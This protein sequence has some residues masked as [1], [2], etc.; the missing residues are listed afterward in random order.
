MKKTITLTLALLGVQLSSYSQAYDGYHDFKIFLGYSNVGGKYGVDFQLDKGLS[1]LVSYGANFTFLIKPDER[2]TTDNVD[3]T[4]KKFDSFDIGAFFRFHFSESLNLSEKVDPYLGVDV[5]LRSIGAHAGI[6]YNFSET[7][8]V[9]AMF[10]H[11]FSSSLTGDH[12]VSGEEYDVF[13]DNINFF[14]KKKH[15]FCRC[16]NQLVLTKYLYYDY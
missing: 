9:Y 12:K 2:E 14:A 4:F 11:S 13:E 5:S 8:G 7:I 16:N 3:N 10:K 1:D 15:N 6:K